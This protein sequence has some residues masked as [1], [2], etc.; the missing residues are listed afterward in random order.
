MI[1]LDGTIDK[2]P[3]DC[4]FVDLI[5]TRIY[6]WFI[7]FLSLHLILQLTKNKKLME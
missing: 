3:Y 2:P 4:V 6:L 5:I 1:D 7:Y